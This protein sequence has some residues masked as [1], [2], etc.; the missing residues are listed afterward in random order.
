MVVNFNDSFEDAL[1]FIRTTILNGFG[2]KEI[3]FSVKICFS[4]SG[5]E[6]DL[7]PKIKCGL[8]KMNDFMKEL[9]EHFPCKCSLCGELRRKISDLYIKLQAKELVFTRDYSLDR[10]NN[11][12][13]GDIAEMYLSAD[14]GSPLSISSL[15]PSL[16]NMIFGEA[17]GCLSQLFLKFISIHI[18]SFQLQEHQIIPH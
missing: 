9:E 3:F 11:L 12:V 10:D 18:A 5:S 2:L 17:K 8:D 7:Y 1:D 15:R 6:V 16:N 14:S 4:E 13:Q